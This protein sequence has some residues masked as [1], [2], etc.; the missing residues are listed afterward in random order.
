MRCLKTS[1][2]IA[3]VIGMTVLSAC[4]P[5][6]YVMD[7]P[8]VME[9]EAS[10]SWPNFTKDLKKN[11]LSKGPTFFPKE[12]E[13]NKKARVYNILNGDLTSKNQE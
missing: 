9:E 3:I 8:T 6:I 4:A 10:G 2:S 5:K 12:K 11:A 7:R 13:N 1:I